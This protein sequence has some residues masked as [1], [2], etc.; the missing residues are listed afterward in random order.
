MKKETEFIKHPLIR[1]SKVLRRTY[2]ERI[3]AS[4]IGENSLIVLP[5]A[6]GK[7][8]IALLMSVFHL[9]NDIDNKVIFLAPTK[10]LVVQHQTSFIEMTILG[11]EKWQLPVLTGAITPDKRGKMFLDAKIAFMTP[12][13]LQNDIIANRIDLSEVA[14]IIFD[15]AHRA[16]GDYAYTFIAEIYHQRKPNGQILAMTASPGGNKEKIEEVCNNLYIKNV[17]IRTKNSDDVKEYVQ[18]VEMQWISIQMP[19]E[20]E[21]PK[22]NI[23]SLLKKF[24]KT[25]YNNNFLD[26]Y[27]INSV[28]RKNLLKSSKKIDARIRIARKNPSLEHEL[29]VLFTMKKVVSNAIRLSHMSELLE[30]QGIRPLY[31]YLKKNI[32]K[33]RDPNSSKSLKE[34][35]AMD[36]MREI[37]HSIQNLN[38]EGFIHPKMVELGE[39]LQKQFYEIT[40][41]RVL[42]F[43]NFRDT[44]SSILSYLKDFK[45]IKATKFVGQASKKTGKKI[46]KGM[47]QKEQL[48]VLNSFKKGKYNTLIATS[49]AE[50]G[51]DIAECDLVV[52][53]DVV[54]SEIRT[55][56]RRGRTARKSAGKVILLMTKGTREE[57]YYWAA[58]RREKNMKKNLKNLK[59]ENLDLDNSK[60]ER[61]ENRGIP[62]SSAMM[63]G[64]EKT[65]MDFVP[66]NGK[67]SQAEPKKTNAEK[68]QDQQS[69]TDHAEKFEDKKKSL[70]NN[71][72][73]LSAEELGGKSQ[74]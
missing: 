41:S 15:E 12:Q 62:E 73:F 36:E 69:E 65:L 58:K 51:L 59:N 67:L 13:V 71:E 25:L 70:N 8:I 43:A 52:F 4:C 38:D 46:I 34:L 48:E 54:P 44:I 5:T 17:E 61:D 49:V 9:S 53:Y 64:K 11:D 39:I 47:T 19:K 33:V 16:V 10:P 26:K 27:G 21:N 31:K 60:K 20:Y 18:D 57:G 55:I 7:T 35:F 37:N 23:E 72:Q 29:K 45:K 28:S 40:Y 63:N 74:G 22:N 42:V 68:T 66:S 30:A 32:A 14:L 2:Q 50:E 1:E 3:F 6:M 24:Y 56:Q